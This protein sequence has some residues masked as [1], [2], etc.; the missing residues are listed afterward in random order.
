MSVFKYDI[1]LSHSIKELNAKCTKDL[2]QTLLGSPISNLPKT[3]IL[4][5]LPLA[6][7]IRTLYLDTFSLIGISNNGF[8]P[9]NY[10]KL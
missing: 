1:K 3:P 5:L 4:L 9:G 7:G 10:S 2:L 6:V 8:L